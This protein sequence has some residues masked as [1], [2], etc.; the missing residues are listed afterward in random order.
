MK[1]VIKMRAER[2]ESDPLAMIAF[3]NILVVATARER[4]RLTG[5]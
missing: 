4:F 5:K 3:I 1:R 2:D